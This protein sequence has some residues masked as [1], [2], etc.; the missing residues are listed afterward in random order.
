MEIYLVDS[1][2]T[3]RFEG[4]PAGVVL[5]ADELSAFE[6]QEIA[7]ELNASE[8]AFVKKGA[9]ADFDVK[10]YTPKTEIAFCGHAT[11]ALFHMLAASGK[12]EVSEQ[13]VGFTESTG[14]GIVPVSLQ[15]VDG[16]VLITM[17]QEQSEIIEP[18]FDAQPVLAS[19][20]LSEKD[21]DKS[22]PLRIARTANRHL[23]LAVKEDALTRINCDGGSHGQLLESVDCVTSY[24]FA[25]GKDDGLNK[26]PRQFKARSFGPHIGIP[27][28][29]A[30]GSAAGAFGAY[31]Y[32]QGLVPD[33]QAEFYILQGADMGRPSHLN[34]KVKSVSG[35]FASVE[36]FGTAVQSFRLLS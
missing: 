29:P 30:T 11:I 2:T 25:A 1:F 24:I 32:A 21:Q 18:P 35:K 34:I 3:K 12:I 23:I 4:N 10:F 7:R 13:P 14:V 20:A 26:V 8:T 16:R 31:L 19:L 36:I 6:M 33:E 28:D 27:E 17:Y 5:N 9:S 15:R 22:F